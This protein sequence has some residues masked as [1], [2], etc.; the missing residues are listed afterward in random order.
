MQ[1]ADSLPPDYYIG[2]LFTLGCLAIS[3][4][5]SV[6]FGK[7]IGET[8]CRYRLEYSPAGRAFGIWGVIY[9]GCLVVCVL[10]LSGTLP[11]LEQRV[12]YWWGGC[13]VCC[14]LWVPLFDDESLWKLAG[15]LVAIGTA[16]ATASIGTAVAGAW[17]PMAWD[18]RQL[19][20]A[21][22]LVWPL[23]LLAGWLITATSLNIGIL[24]EAMDPAANKTCVFVHPQT[25]G[26]TDQQ[27]NARRRRLIR[28]RNAMAP[29]VVAFEVWVIAFVVAGATMVVR[30]PVLALPAIWA[31]LNMKAFPSCEYWYAI[32]VCALGS[33]GAVAIAWM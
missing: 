4:I 27:F 28:E 14:G 31:I 12:F 30:D 19:S 29:A 9:G 32:V 23:G 11:V 10:Q 26:E 8:S 16:A 7:N 3:I 13:W 20:V 17:V 1:P 33:A 15:A 25:L 5:S 2:P 21:P 22:A 24:L 18:E 6:R